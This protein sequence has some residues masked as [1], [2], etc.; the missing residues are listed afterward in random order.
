M[1]EAVADAAADVAKAAVAP[2]CCKALAMKHAVSEAVF[3]ECVCWK[4]PLCKA[5]LSKVA[6][7]ELVVWKAL[8]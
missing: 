4:A 6:A 5:G 3:A 7:A 1:E 8:L 2:V